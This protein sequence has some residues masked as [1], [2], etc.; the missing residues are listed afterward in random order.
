MLTVFI[1]LYILYYSGSMLSGYEASEEGLS[2]MRCYLQ[3]VLSVAPEALRVELFDRFFRGY[4][5]QLALHPVAN[6][7]VQA[8]LA[9]VRTTPEV[10]MREGL[11]SAICQHWL[12]GSA[13]MMTSGRHSRRGS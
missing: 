12:V 13:A 4:L 8:A 10:G 7:V 9:A 1:L 11:Q 5:A 2:H 3:V 6:F